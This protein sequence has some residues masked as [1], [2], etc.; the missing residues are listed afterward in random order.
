PPGTEDAARIRRL[1]LVHAKDDKLVR[2]AKFLQLKDRLHLPPDQCLVLG[3]GGHEARGREHEVVDAVL[4]FLKS[5][6]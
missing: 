6:L 3:S 5:R 1:F 2:F 4:E